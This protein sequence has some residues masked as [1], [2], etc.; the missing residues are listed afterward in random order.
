MNIK[1]GKKRLLIGVPVLS[2]FLAI[3]GGV[4]LWAEYESIGY[5]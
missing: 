3:F 5:V 4:R 1:K 2:S